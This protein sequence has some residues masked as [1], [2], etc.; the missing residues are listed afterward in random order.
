MHA[1]NPALTPA[2]VMLT[3]KALAEP[4]PGPS[5]KSETSDDTATQAKTLRSPTRANLEGAQ[6]HQVDARLR[7]ADVRQRAHRA[8]LRQDHDR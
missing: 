3:M 6:I 4:A 1:K 8:D 7:R 2:S 5:Q